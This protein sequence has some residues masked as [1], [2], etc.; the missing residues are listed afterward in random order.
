MQ[1]HCSDLSCPEKFLQHWGVTG[2]LDLRV[3]VVV[4]AIEEGFKIK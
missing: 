3:Q 2:I 1:D 4:D